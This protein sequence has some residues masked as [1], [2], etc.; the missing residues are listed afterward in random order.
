MDHSAALTREEGFEAEFATMRSRIARWQERKSA[1]IDALVRTHGPLH[2]KAF[3]A[4]ASILT[5]LLHLSE[6]KVCSFHEKPGSLKIGHYV[7]G[8]RIPIVSDHDLFHN[9]DVSVPVLNFASHIS[10]EIRA[11]LLQHGY[12]GEVVDIVTPEDFAP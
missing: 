4:R 10:G 8:T 5:R 11:Y 9:G 3:P 2:A 12:K 7:P 1:K 6:K